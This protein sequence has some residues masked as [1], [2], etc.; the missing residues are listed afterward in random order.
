MSNVLKRQI[1]IS[2]DRTKT[3]QQIYDDVKAESVQL[4]LEDALAEAD[5]AQVGGPP[6]PIRVLLIGFEEDD[7]RVEQFRDSLGCGYAV[8]VEQFVTRD[9]VRMMRTAMSTYTVDGDGRG[10][11]CDV[12]ED[13]S[14]PISPDVDGEGTTDAA[15]EC[16]EKESKEDKMKRQ[17]QVRRA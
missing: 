10:A 16:K 6:D 7:S 13:S 2:V 3:L 1:Y 5:L 9:W 14:R 12:L 17:P 11:A 8:G 15:V 4:P